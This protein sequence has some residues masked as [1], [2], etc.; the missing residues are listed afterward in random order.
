MSPPRITVLFHDSPTVV[1]FLNTKDGGALAGDLLIE[2]AL[3]PALGFVLNFETPVNYPGIAGVLSGTDIGMLAHPTDHLPAPIILAAGSA[4]SRTAIRGALAPL[5]R[6]DERLAALTFLVPMAE[7]R[8]LGSAL[9]IADRFAIAWD[10]TAYPH[11]ELVD[12]ARWF[13]AERLCDDQSF[14]GLFPYATTIVEAAHAQRLG[15][16]LMPLAT[17]APGI[18][19]TII[20]A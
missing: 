15:A 10:V 19:A 11:E 18:R 20:S 17:R 2:C 8:A 16:M 4:V 7:A 9:A 6:P 13:S 14:A 5:Q 3:Q 12:F 1:T